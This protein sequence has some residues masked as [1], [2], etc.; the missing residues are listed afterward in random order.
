[1]TGLTLIVVLAMLCIGIESGKITFFF[2]LAEVSTERFDPGTLGGKSRIAGVVIY[3]LMDL[4]LGWIGILL[5]I[6]AT[7]STFPTMMERGAIDVLLAKPVSRP[8]LFFYKYIAGMVF[9]LLQ[10][11]LFVGLTFLV[12]G[13]R[14]SA[15]VP[16]YL[17][18]IPL[19]VLL[20]SYLYCVSVL[21]AVKTRSTVAAILLSIGA[22]VFFSAPPTVL[23]MF[24]AFPSLKEYHQVYQSVRVASWIVPKTTDIPYL[25]ARWARAGTSMD[26]F[27]EEMLQAATEEDRAQLDAARQVEQ[28]ILGR[29]P[30]L[31]VGSSLLFEAVI[32]LWAMWVFTRTDF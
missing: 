24:D 18:S 26:I 8:R 6:I 3:L 19:L 7:A 15:W 10:S 13:F 32:V 12:M 27:P 16:G 14:W 31:S 25:A 5:M 30:L 22:W 4:L 2:G 21:V 29:S 9:A 28:K 17:F 1:M 23:Q 20:F 11:S